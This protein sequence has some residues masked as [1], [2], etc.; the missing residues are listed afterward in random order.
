M[1]TLCVSWG[2]QQHHLY[3]KSTALSSENKLNCK[4]SSQKKW[5]YHTQGQDSPH[6]KQDLRR[7]HST[8]QGTV[9]EFDTGQ[10][11][12]KS[13]FSHLLI[14]WLWELLDLFNLQFSHLR[15]WDSDL[16]LKGCGEAEKSIIFVKY[17]MS[18]HSK[19]LTTDINFCYQEL[20]WSTYFFLF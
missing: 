13:C 4:Y 6:Q 8:V 19:W 1:Y 11:S 18:W 12:F 2:C 10:P 16:Y 14:L 17:T 5:R 9:E 15:H 7:R 20:R 3:L